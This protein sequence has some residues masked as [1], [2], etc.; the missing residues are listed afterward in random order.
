MLAGLA[1]VCSVRVGAVDWSCEV[2][3]SVCEHAPTGLGVA[4]VLVEVGG[5][6]R[7]LGAR[8]CA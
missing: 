4:S 5:V 3:V 6:S 2:G 7:A 8:G 1:G